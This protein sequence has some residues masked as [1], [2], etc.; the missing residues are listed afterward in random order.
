MAFFLEGACFVLGFDMLC[1][2]SRR[3]IHL[4]YMQNAVDCL[5]IMIPK[6]DKALPQV[7]ILVKGIQ[8][9]ISSS[10]ALDV[11]STEVSL[12][13]PLCN[14]NAS[15]TASADEE[16]ILGNAKHHFSQIQQHTD[17]RMID[18]MS[19]E[20][21]STRQY[22]T[23]SDLEYNW[24]NMSIEMLWPEYPHQ[25]LRNMQHTERFVPNN[26]EIVE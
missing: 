23:I 16:T 12:V 15:A 14:G 4:P 5:T 10:V 7:R 3:T 18:S 19:Y 22:S 25:L 9:I 17:S 6:Q 13:D 8:K 11:Q 1:H 2:I 26:G 20:G 24:Q 21:L